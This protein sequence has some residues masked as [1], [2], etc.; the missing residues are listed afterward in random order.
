LPIQTLLGRRK[1]GKGRTSRLPRE[2]VRKDPQSARRRKEC[3][4]Q[5]T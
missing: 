5:K 3:K 2:H 1:R 4:W